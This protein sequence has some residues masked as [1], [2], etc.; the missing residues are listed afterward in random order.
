MLAVSAV[1]GCMLRNL[2]TQVSALR[3]RLQDGFSALRELG[4]RHVCTAVGLEACR[5][6]ET[7][8]DRESE[9]LQR[10][11]QF[12]KR[13][14]ETTPDDDQWELMRQVAG[15]FP[16]DIVPSDFR[17]PSEI[18]E[19][20]LEVMAAM[21]LKYHGCDPDANGSPRHEGQSRAAT[22]TGH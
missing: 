3:R 13:I 6:S 14:E 5:L 4:N 17:L 10:A 2:S 19:E 21:R 11:L 9:N 7:F 20:H 22:G 15:L 12:Y 16:T 8:L 18:V 1:F